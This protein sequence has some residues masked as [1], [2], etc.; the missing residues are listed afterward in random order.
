MSSSV[1]GIRQAGWHFKVAL[2]ACLVGLAVAAKLTVLHIEVHHD[3]DLE[4]FCAISESVNCDTVALSPYSVFLGV[5]VAVWGIVG[6]LLMSAAALW[7]MRSRKLSPATAILLS[8]A[9]VSV[10][11][12]I[13]L[14]YIAMTQIE[15][16]C[17]LCMTTYLVNVVLLGIMLHKS[18]RLGFRTIYGKA[19]R[20]LAQAG[21][22]PR[23]GALGV[24][25][26]VVLLIS[27][28]PQ[29]WKAPAHTENQASLTKKTPG[30]PRVQTGLTEEGYPWVG[31]AKPSVTIVEFSD[32]Q[33]PFCSRRHQELR[34]LVEKN[35]KRLRLVH[36][37]FPLDPACNPILDRPFHPYACQYAQFAACACKL[38]KFWEVND[39][40][41]ANSRKES[42]IQASQLCEAVRLDVSALKRCIQKGFDELLGEDLAAG[43]SLEIRG[44]PSFLVNGQLY[45]GRLPESALAP[46]VRLSS[47]QRSSG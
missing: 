14:S 33:C 12:S 45:M 27:F 13:V 20:W 39:Y 17:I 6:Y 40:L 21:A 42:P 43:I 5:P 34:T 19:Q 29:Y 7:G 22:S 15:S 3:P 30:E 41:Y 37:H 18:R 36:R 26:L 23:L 47:F 24:T 35:P 31:A 10:L 11:V 28:Y 16:V 4:S 38:G 46:H 44:T 8:L 9:F 2:G 32:Y 25:V 1:Q